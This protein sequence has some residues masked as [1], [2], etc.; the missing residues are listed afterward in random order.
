MSGPTTTPYRSTLT[1]GRDTFGRLLLAEWTKLRSVRRWL[2]TLIS[3][4]VLT[5]LVGL[6]IASG[7]GGTRD[8]AGE[9][10]GGKVDLA[11]HFMD[12]GQFVERE[13]TGDGELIARVTTQERSA[14]RA[15]AGLMI[16]ASDAR[17]AAYA[18]VVVTPDHGVRLQSAYGR[19]QAGGGGPAPRWLKLVRAGRTITAYESSDG[20]AWRRVGRVD[21]GRLPQTARIG[22]YVGSPDAVEVER[23]FGSEGISGQTTT[24]KA[25][26]DH[27]SL[28]PAQPQQ[29]TGPWRNRV[30]PDGSTGPSGPAV[31]RPDAGPPPGFTEADGTFTVIGSG[32]IGLDRFGD[33]GTQTIL[34]GV[35][36]GMIAVV[37]LGVL[38]I[39]AEFH[40]DTIRTTFAAVPRRGRVLA[41]KAI[42]L[43]AATFVVG[44]LGAFGAFLI[45]GPVE[46]SKDRIPAGLSDPNV[47]RALIGTAALLALVAMLA[48]AIGTILRRAAPAIAVVLALLLLPRIIGSGLSVSTATWLERL[49]P[50]AGFAI[51]RTF[52]RYDSTIGP[53]TGLGV[54]CGYAAVALVFAGWRL[55]RRDT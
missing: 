42:V 21:P 16:R 25:T 8:V 37:A 44:L 54:L 6:L 30:G 33:D 43:G 2:L 48:L 24:G 5:V 51:Q 45:T 27:V 12:G 3:A 17:G 15:K 1:G 35:L 53:W 4:A 13:L 29:P 28:T 31:D 46:R 26:F 9:G 20:S 14:G 19:D 39:T 49:T 40:R 11:E 23:Q 38:S 55:H 36:I 32:D 34:G 18:A 7:T 10:G 41:A 50:A 52:D 22:L 47:L